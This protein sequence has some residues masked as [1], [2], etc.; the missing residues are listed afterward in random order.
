M[1]QWDG[2]HTRGGMVGK[3][4]EMRRKVQEFWVHL[5]S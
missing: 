5:I 4:G 3:G 1:V 2:G